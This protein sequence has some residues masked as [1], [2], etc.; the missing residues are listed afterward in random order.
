M[1]GQFYIQ[2]GRYHIPV[3]HDSFIKII[4]EI[5]SVWQIYKSERHCDCTRYYYIEDSEDYSFPTLIYFG[6]FDFCYCGENDYPC[7]R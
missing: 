5:S 6:Y 1:S 7:D 3:N 2:V 4:D